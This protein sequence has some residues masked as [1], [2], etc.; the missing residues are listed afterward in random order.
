MITT[1]NDKVIG[2]YYRDRAIE[3]LYLG[4]L[5]GRVFSREVIV[6]IS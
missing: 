1:T 4:G 2:A 3:G 6:D 5:P